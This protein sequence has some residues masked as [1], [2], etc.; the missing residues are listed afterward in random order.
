MAEA[1]KVT[2]REI[3]D[4]DFNR[5]IDEVMDDVLR[6]VTFDLTNDELDA[7]ENAIQDMLRNLIV[8][9]E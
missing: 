7:I 6:R 1:F 5:L 4:H 2:T 9:P 8:L 3:S